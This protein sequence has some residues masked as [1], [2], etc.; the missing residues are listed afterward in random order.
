MHAPFKK[1]MGEGKADGEE[2]KK[3]KKTPHHI[4]RQ[5][6]KFTNR[7]AAWSWKKATVNVIWFVKYNEV[8]D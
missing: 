4:R 2:K 6:K 5:L 3:K 7:S 8:S 1:A